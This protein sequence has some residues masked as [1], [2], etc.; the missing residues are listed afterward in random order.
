M[1]PSFHLHPEGASLSDLGATPGA[2]LLLVELSKPLSLTLAGKPRVLRPGCHA[3]CGSACGPGGLAARLAR[4]LRAEKR[5]HWHID[6]LTAAGRIGPVFAWPGG[7]ECGLVTALCRLP[8]ARIP[9]PGFGS[10]DCRACPAHLV[11]LPA[12]QDLPDLPGLCRVLPGADS[13]G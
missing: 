3:Y 5:P 8:G 11:Q 12:S 2:Y 9:L 4:H 7:S 6:R 10:S 1:K 13:E